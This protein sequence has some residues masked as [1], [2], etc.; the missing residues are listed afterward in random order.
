MQ[1]QEVFQSKFDI[2]AERKKTWNNRN[3]GVRLRVDPEK[4]YIH[5]KKHN[6]TVE[7]KEKP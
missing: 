2:R 7:E 4:N 3:F 6:S 5:Q 1:K